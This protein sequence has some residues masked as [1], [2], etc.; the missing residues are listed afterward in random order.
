MRF[1]NLLT[2]RRLYLNFGLVCPVE[3]V[4]D[5]CISAYFTQPMEATHIVAVLCSNVLSANSRG[6]QNTKAGSPEGKLSLIAGKRFFQTS[7]LCH[8]LAQPR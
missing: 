5:G 2:E 7:A 8:T 3:K 1:P 4:A 6:L